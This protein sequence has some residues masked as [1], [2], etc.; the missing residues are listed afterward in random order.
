MQSAEF[1]LHFLENA[2]EEMETYLLQPELFWPLSSSAGVRQ[3]FPRLTIANV[4]LTLNELEAQESEL[5]PAQYSKATSLQTKWE[6]L[7]TKW[8]TAVETKAVE[9]MGA[10][11]NL[12]K[13]YIT[14]LEENKG[15][16]SNYDQEV[17]QRVRLALLRERIGDATVPDE[18]IDM[19]RAVDR[20]GLA[21]TV[22]SEFVWDSRLEPIYSPDDYIFL[23]RK[24]K[25][26]H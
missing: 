23:Y 14:D 24:P 21:L 17:T 5:A 9:E 8:L 25:Q 15:Q 7:H 11:L 6:V 20:R 19:I 26:N 2:L 13:A 18:L 4:L 1:N 16:Q 3:D 12:W 22:P 10:R